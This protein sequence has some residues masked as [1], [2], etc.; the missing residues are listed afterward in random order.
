MQTASPRDQISRPRLERAS[1][2]N[3][4]LGGA[5]GSEWGGGE[6]SPQL[7]PQAP[8]R[9]VQWRLWLPAGPHKFARGVLTP[10]VSERDPIWKQGLCRR[11]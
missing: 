1:V 8:G 5:R 2:E 4:E 7:L 9:D 6:G 11:N 10:S 3:D